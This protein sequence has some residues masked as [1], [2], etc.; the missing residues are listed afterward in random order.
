MKKH[1][2]LILVPVLLLTLAA[3]AFAFSCQ[4]SAQS[5]A[6]DGRTV[7]CDKYNID[8]SNYFKLRDLAQLLNGTGSQ[9][10]VGWDGDSQLVS[11]TTNHAYTAPNGT[12][13]LVGDD[14]SVTAQVSAQTI[15]VDGAVRGDLT[16][17]NIGGSNFFKLRELGDALGFVVDYDDATNTAI[18]ESASTVE[19]VA[20]DAMLRSAAETHL[21]EQTLP[22]AFDGFSDYLVEDPSSE[23]L[24]TPEE[25]AQ[26]T[27]KSGE[28]NRGKQVSYA[29]AAADVDL[30]LRALKDG[31]GAYYYF[32]GDAAFDKA[33]QA[34]LAALP[35]GGTVDAA[36][37]GTLLR[38]KL[39]FLVDGHCRIEGTSVAELPENKYQFYYCGQS[40][41]KDESGYYRMVGG[42]KWYYAGCAVNAA[43]MAP[44]LGSDGAIVYSPVVW[45]PAPQLTAADTMTMRCGTKTQTV[46]IQWTQATPYAQRPMQEEICE[47]LEEQGILY[48][49]MRN[50]RSENQEVVQRFL[51]AAAQARE[52]KA[53]IFDLRSNG[54]G[55]GRC[56]IPWM[57]IFKGTENV[58][59]RHSL[60]YSDRYSLLFQNRDQ[61]AAKY[62][63]TLYD[64]SFL[65][66]DVPVIALVD[67]NNGSNGEDFVSLLKTLDNV[68]VLGANTGG[69][70]L[71]GNMAE[72][73]LPNTGMAFAFGRCLQFNY[74]QENMDGKGYAPDVWCDPVNAL[75]C[76]LAMLD[77]Y[78]LAP[79]KTVETL[80]QQLDA[81]LEKHVNLQ[82]K[83]EQFTVDPNS[84]FG[85][86]WGTHYID[87]LLDGAAITDFE[88]TSGNE[89]VCTVSKDAQGRIVLNAFG[90]GDSIITVTARGGH[91]SFRWHSE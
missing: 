28:R 50:F 88:V 38:E 44:Y 23:N 81:E 39:S 10:D 77:R 33:K 64:A 71:C 14:Q 42:E 75:D 13:L 1:I 8:G 32:G 70:Q 35:A 56:M 12:E 5:L 46:A 27:T 26:L 4:R 19:P 69:Y 60:A 11:I 34:V 72:F 29:E 85:G 40:F 67:N 63:G 45:C 55:S 18:V 47:V 31:Y 48:I 87:V 21:A 84:G 78:D 3:P 62:K 58:T 59:Y 25:V 41:S 30:Y 61:N 17:Y 36:Q 54:G 91:Q 66:N 2:A 73:C 65:P 20:F 51:N 83:W 49:S 9:F 7:A 79:E 22:G 6:V 74:R 89:S 43:E 24:L 16:V 80:R 15:M 86:G 53:L 37:L 57:N 76:V 82:L 52:A 90:A 68:L